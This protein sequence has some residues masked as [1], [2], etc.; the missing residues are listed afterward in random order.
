MPPS[1]T[2]Q[3]IGT[4]RGLRILVPLIAAVAICGGCSR[5]EDVKRAVAPVEPVPAPQTVQATP[6]QTVQPE[7]PQVD[8]REAQFEQELQGLQKRIDDSITAIAEADLEIG[9]AERALETAKYS[10]VPADEMPWDAVSAAHEKK[11][12]AL[13]ERLR[14]NDELKALYARYGK[15][16]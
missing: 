10:G 7:A 16:P 3:Y 12:K 11:A 15:V 8:P 5:N 1:R 2:L 14:L 6:D 4:M 13:E 9:E